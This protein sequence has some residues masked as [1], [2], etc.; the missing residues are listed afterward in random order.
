MPRYLDGAQTPLDRLLHQLNAK[1]K[2]DEVLSLPLLSNSQENVSMHG[3]ITSDR[4]DSISSGRN[5]AT[6]EQILPSPVV[7]NKVKNSKYKRRII[8]KANVIASTD[9]T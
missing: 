7:Q 9:A 5:V 8:S 6:N 1:K 4:K 3:K 2:L